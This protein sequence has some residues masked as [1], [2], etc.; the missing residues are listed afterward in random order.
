MIKYNFRYRG[1]YEYEKFLLMALQF[2]NEVRYLKKAM[3]SGEFSVFDQRNKEIQDLFD[4]LTNE[5]GIM[6]EL[7]KMSIV[8]ENRGITSDGAQ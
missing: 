1:P 2:S 4:K 7:L 5:N 8:V 3:E 6:S